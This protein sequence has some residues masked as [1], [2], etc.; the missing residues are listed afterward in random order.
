MT[1]QR[2][3]YEVLG[4]ARN[5]DGATLKSAYRRLAKQYHPDANPGDASAE[6]RF[7]EISEAYAILSDGDKRARY[8]RFGRAAFENGAGGGP[9]GYT[10]FQDIFNEVFGETFGSFFSQG[11]GPGRGGLRGA[12]L[13]FDMEITL[14]QALAGVEKQI[15]VS[16]AVSCKVCHGSGAA[17]GT[18]PQTCPTCGGAGQVRANQGLFRVV[19]TCPGCSG[20]GSIVRNPCHG[21]SGRGVNQSDRQL[22]VKIPAGVEDGTRIRLA[23]EGDAAPFGGQT[24][25]LYLFLSIKPHEIFERDGSELFCRATVPMTTAALG[26]EIEIPM[27]EGGRTRITIPAGSQSGRRFR[28]RHAGMSTLRGRDRGDLHVEIFVETPVNLSAK[29]RR[30]LEEFALSCGEEAHP[31]S[32][33]FFATVR[34][35]FE[36]DSETSSR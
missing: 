25:D 6:A 31:Q 33:G 15:R 10:D 17:E 19:R 20:R 24:G 13:R 36:A 21:C 27:L 35:F 16:S 11:A 12:D 7:K 4:V 18:A 8:D 29:Q 9:G 30:I 34:R 2:D 26:G 23:G 28:V 3:L 22:S 32:N 14:E 5:A 1:S